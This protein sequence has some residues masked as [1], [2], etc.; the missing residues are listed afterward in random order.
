MLSLRFLIFHIQTQWDW[1]ETGAFGSADICQTVSAVHSVATMVCKHG[2]G[3]TSVYRWVNFLAI[4]HLEQTGQ[5]FIDFEY[6]YESVC[7]QQSNTKTYIFTQKT[8]L[9]SMG[10]IN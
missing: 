4:A 10:W 9:E 7:V 6:F 8:S 2:G 3:D 1:A 5:T